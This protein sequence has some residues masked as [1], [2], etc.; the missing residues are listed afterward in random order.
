MSEQGKLKAE[1]RPP[2]YSHIPRAS[3]GK[4]RIDLVPP[5]LIEGAARG[6]GSGTEK[7]ATHDDL[8]FLR[9]YTYKDVYA[10]M[11][12]H[13]LAWYA[14]EELDKESGL[15]H[16]DHAASNLAMLMHYIRT[17][18]ADDDRPFRADG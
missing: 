2:T 12:R 3:E 1:A 16:L 18:V 5:A 7:Y 17:N 8:N 4:L 13:I 10:S 9:A 14:G 11:M 15:S 6:L